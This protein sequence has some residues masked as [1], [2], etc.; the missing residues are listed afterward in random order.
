M[1]HW[2][3][4][5]LGTA[6]ATALLI[7][8]LGCASMFGSKKKEDSK[9]D[10]F[11]GEVTVLNQS[12]QALCGVELR[13]RKAD[14]YIIHAEK[15]EVEGTFKATLKGAL[16]DLYVMDCS[17][18]ML[19]KGGA[20]LYHS[21]LIISPVGTKGDGGDHTAIA[22]S[23]K[24][25]SF[26]VYLDKLRSY[27]RQRGTPLNDPKASAGIL[28][29]AQAGFKAKNWTHNAEVILIASDRWFVANDNMSRQVAAAVGQRFKS[30]QCNV[31]IHSFGQSGD[32][33]KF[34]GPFVHKGASYATSAPCA[35]LAWMK[36]QKGAAK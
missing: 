19:Y 6:T 33:E 3:T 4:K 5:L 2:T 26:Q 22:I 27:A 9:P 30:G 18:N 15:L 7:S 1:K 20:K 12:G 25:Q 11:V 23:A 24:P 8:S 16:S 28:Q 10:A 21:K 36:A 17:G 31:Q 14:D 13:T 34:E 32:G 35:M 29:A